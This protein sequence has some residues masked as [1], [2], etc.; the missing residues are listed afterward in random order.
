M[1]MNTPETRATA[2][3]NAAYRQSADRGAPVRRLSMA[4]PTIHGAARDT[5]PEATA[6]AAP[7]TVGTRCP[8]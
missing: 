7:N 1:N 8:R 2:T 4:R 3:S 5:T 6:L